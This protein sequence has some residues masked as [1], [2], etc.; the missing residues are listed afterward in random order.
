MPDLNPMEWRIDQQDFKGSEYY[1]S[2]AV[3][4]THVCPTDLK[5]SN[6]TSLQLWKSKSR[7]VLAVNNASQFGALIVSS[8]MDCS[9]VCVSAFTASR[10]SPSFGE[11]NWALNLESEMGRPYS[12]TAE[13]LYLVLSV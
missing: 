1:L 4:M 9:I 7:A 11:K 6:F 13:L 8:I 3:K 2:I 5:S 12:I 10:A